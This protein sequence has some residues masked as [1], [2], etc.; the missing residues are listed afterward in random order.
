M[1]AIEDL[2]PSHVLVVF[3]HYHDLLD[4][5][6]LQDNLLPFISLFTQHIRGLSL[7]VSQDEARKVIVVTTPSTDGNL[8]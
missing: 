4:G 2:E 6:R 8:G 1:I 7:V 5:V 3:L